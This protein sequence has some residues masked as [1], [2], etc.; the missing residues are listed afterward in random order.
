[1]TWV[2]AIV[3]DAR[4]LV[5]P[6]VA[7]ALSSWSPAAHASDDV[8]TL[9]K[10]RDRIV[11][12]RHSYAP[13]EPPDADLENLK[14]CKTQRNLDETGRAQARR[15]GDEF[16]KRGIRPARIHSSQYCRSLETARLLNLGAVAELA[17][18][19]Q[20]FYA[21]PLEMREAADKTRQFIKTIAGRGLSVLV[22]HVTNIQALA[23]AAVAS[24][25]FAVVHLNP[26]GEIVVDGRILIK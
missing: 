7:L 25:E 1:L 24:G 15:V 19:N 20:T 26:S 8:W 11:L 18:L 16:R 6:I 23:G 4:W 21:K 22:T 13:E 3:P 12:L 10:K 5:F 9:L 17:A 2:R 14:N